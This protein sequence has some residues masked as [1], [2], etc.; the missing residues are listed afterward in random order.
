MH[1]TSKDHTIQS[2]RMIYDR[3]H[4]VIILELD[5]LQMYLNTK[6]HMY[7]MSGKVD[8]S[9]MVTPPLPTSHFSYGM[10]QD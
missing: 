2:F 4:H 7:Y 3:I 10:K 8:G 6:L 5:L 1:I 9:W